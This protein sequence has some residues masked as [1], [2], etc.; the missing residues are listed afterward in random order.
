ME[1]HFRYVEPESERWTSRGWPRDM[2]ATAR[3]IYKAARPVG[4]RLA[5]R[6]VR[7]LKWA[8][9]RWSVILDPEIMTIIPYFLFDAILDSRVR[10]NHACL[11]G[12][13][14]PASWAGWNRF[15]PPLGPGC[16]CT[17]VAITGVRARRL[18]AEGAPYFDVR[19]SPP[20]N[21]GPDAGWDRRDGWWEE[22]REICRPR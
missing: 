7:A 14:A 17:L 11:D 16:R 10:P 19:L 3:A 4:V 1:R 20:A 5:P 22:L 8:A 18:L 13:I 12:G 2:S 21:A 6:D 9:V 15:A